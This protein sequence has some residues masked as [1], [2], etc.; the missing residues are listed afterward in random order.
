MEKIPLR[1]FDEIVAKM[2]REEFWEYLKEVR[3]GGVFSTLVSSGIKR[4]NS[5]PNSK[6]KK[7]FLKNTFA[8]KFPEKYFSTDENLEILASAIAGRSTALR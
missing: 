6:A 8:K 3:Q 7:Q 5:L 1:E 4:L 2:P